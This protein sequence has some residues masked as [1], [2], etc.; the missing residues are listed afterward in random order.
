MAREETRATMVILEIILYGGL[1]VFFFNY[2]SRAGRAP[3]KWFGGSKQAIFHFNL[4]ENV[5]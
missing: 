4:F 2:K 1:S 5:G 3:F